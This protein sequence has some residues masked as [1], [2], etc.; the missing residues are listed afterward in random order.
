MNIIT[1]IRNLIR[2][3]ALIST[4][5]LLAMLALPAKAALPFTA[6][7]F[8]MWQWS[9]PGMWETNVNNS[10]SNM[11]Q[12]L[13]PPNIMGQ[14]G[15]MT[16]RLLVG[17]P[18][19]AVAHHTYIGYAGGSGSP[20][21]G[22]TI[23]FTNDVTGPDGYN[24]FMNSLYLAGTN[25]GTQAGM[26]VNP[27]GTTNITAGA[28][29]VVVKAFDTSTNWYFTIVATAPSATNIMGVIGCYLRAVSLP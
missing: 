14:R 7:Q 9:A 3:F 10:P 2:T 12:V 19:N 11:V 25:T 16:V 13:V 27:S 17:S 28:T 8:P 26:Y 22:G 21:S 23:L 18:D 5:A 24:I 6:Q 20:L 4:L 15:Y 29:A 1:R